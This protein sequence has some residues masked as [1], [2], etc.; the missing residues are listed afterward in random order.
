MLGDVSLSGGVAGRRNLARLPGI[1]TNSTRN[2]P[3]FRVVV[4]RSRAIDIGGGV[5]SMTLR[6]SPAFTSS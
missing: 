1:R 4:S 3:A 6:E 2:R 5:A